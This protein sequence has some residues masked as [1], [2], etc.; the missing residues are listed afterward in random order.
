MTYPAPAYLEDDP[1]FGPAYYS[2][3]QE[4][5]KAKHDLCVAEDLLLAEETTGVPNDI[6]E[7]MYQIATGHGKT[8]VQLDPMT[9]LGGGSEQIQSG[10]GRWMSG[11]GN[12]ELFG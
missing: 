1:W 7:R 8:T 4:I 3:K 5:L 12:Q 9:G 11:T 2:E 6:H 10:P